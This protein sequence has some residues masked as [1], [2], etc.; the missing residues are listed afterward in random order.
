[1][2]KS[3]IAQSES[4]ANKAL[5]S[6]DTARGLLRDVPLEERRRIPGLNPDRADIIAAGVAVI[7]RLT[8][9]LGAREIIS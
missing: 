5:H 6:D 3:I 8:G 7:A 2:V 9:R 4:A 1:M